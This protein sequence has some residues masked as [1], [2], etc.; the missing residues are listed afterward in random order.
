MVFSFLKLKDSITGAAKKI[1][2]TA[3]NKEPSGAIS[4]LTA[5]LERAIYSLQLFG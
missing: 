5:P 2:R 3:L 4:S 1:K